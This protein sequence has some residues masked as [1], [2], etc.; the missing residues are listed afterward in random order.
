MLYYVD[1]P[2][3]YFGIIVTDDIVRKA[4]PIGRWMVGN[5]LAYIERWV[6]SKRGTVCACPVATHQ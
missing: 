2:Y 5:S 1:L 6:R 3:A 4:A